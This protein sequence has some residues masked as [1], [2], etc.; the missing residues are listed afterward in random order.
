MRCLGTLRSLPMIAAKPDWGGRVVVLTWKVLAQHAKL[1]LEHLDIEQAFV[2]GVCMGVGVATQFARIY[3][4]ACTGLVLAQPVGGHRWQVRTHAFFNRHLEF[5]CE[6]GL[7]A[8]R[9]C[10]T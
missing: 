2:L 4:E 3:P 1:L 10:V 9:E 7:A 8:V 5:I 6:N